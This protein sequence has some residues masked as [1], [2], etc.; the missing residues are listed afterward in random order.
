[1]QIECIFVGKTTSKYIAQ[2]IDDFAKR[3]GRYCPVKI[4]YSKE[5]KGKLKSSQILKDEG[6]ALLDLIQKGSLIVVLDVCGKQVNSEELAV[7]VG[8]WQN[9]GRKHIT[10][11]IGGHLGLSKEVLNAADLTL[12]L[13]KMT[14]THEMARMILL[15]Q[16]YR[17]FAILAGSQY[18]K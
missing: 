15:E 4:R 12:S 9:Q 10:F 2:G 5:K 7:Q 16:V 13:S 1:M 3:L 17:A 6:V 11:M 8:Q 18:H 14:F